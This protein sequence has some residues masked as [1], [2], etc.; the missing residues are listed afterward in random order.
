MFSNWSLIAILIESVRNFDGNE[1]NVY[2]YSMLSVHSVN[3]NA[4]NQVDWVDKKRLADKSIPWICTQHNVDHVRIGK[5]N[6]F[7]VDFQHF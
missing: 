7:C 1:Y 3:H 2:F 5:I 4:I 6:T